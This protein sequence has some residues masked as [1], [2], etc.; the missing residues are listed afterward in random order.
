LENRCAI[1]AAGG[2]S[3][4]EGTGTTRRWRRIAGL[5]LVTCAL[6]LACVIGAYLSQRVPLL[7]YPSWL[8][9]VGHLVTHDGDAFHL[10]VAMVWI[11]AAGPRVEW[12]L[13]H[14]RYAGFLVVATYA[15]ALFQQFALPTG[16]A[17]AGAG[18]LATA[19]LGAS[20]VLRPMAPL[21]WRLFVFGSVRALIPAAFPSLIYFALDVTNTLDAIRK[22]D[23]LSGSHDLYFAHLYGFPIGMAVA[24]LLRSR[25]REMAAVNQASG[26]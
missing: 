25:R 11:G 10:F 9:P 16:S 20:V 7:E 3:L 26:E 5:P 4:V 17:I 18:G 14:A 8:A 19:V 23:L 12:L 2:A 13:G 15:T 21:R 22:Q 1:G 6:V 24:S